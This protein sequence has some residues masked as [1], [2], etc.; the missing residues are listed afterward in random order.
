MPVAAV[1]RLGNS[2][3][4]HDLI[5]EFAGEPPKRVYDI[6]AGK[7]EAFISRAAGLKA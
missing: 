1:R 3:P 2:K 6:E 4:V 7:R 5:T